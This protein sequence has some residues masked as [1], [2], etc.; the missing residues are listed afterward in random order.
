MSGPR[1]AWRDDTYLAGFQQRRLSG[2]PDDDR[3]F[4]TLVRHRSNTPEQPAIL[5][6]HGY[7]D[8]FY[9][10]SVGDFFARSGLAF[11]ALDLHGFGRSLTSTSVPNYASNLRTYWVDIEDSV[12]ALA[13]E[14]HGEVVLAGH[15]TG[16]LILSDWWGT[17]PKIGVKVKGL[18]LNSPFLARPFPLLPGRPL[19][20]ALNAVARMKPLTVVPRSPS[21]DYGRALHAATGGEWD[22]DLG[23]KPH[24]SFPIRAGW[25]NA[26]LAAQQRVALRRP[27]TDL[28]ILCVAAVQRDVDQPASWANGGDV[29]LPVPPMVSAAARL[30]YQVRIELVQGA[31]HDVFSSRVDVREHA[32]EIALGWMREVLRPHSPPFHM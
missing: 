9:Q 14:G 18:L 17:D 23:L 24:A 22:Y 32:S 8:Y 28:P 26:V 10:E 30:S 11:Y 12:A 4:A 19:D 21:G 13:E 15:S 25:L 6:I 29:V 20:R 31:I 1:N 5:W 3:P 7:A 27:F 2:G 16:G